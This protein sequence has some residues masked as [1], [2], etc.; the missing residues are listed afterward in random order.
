MS[1]KN[2]SEI[3]SRR[4]LAQAAALGG[5]GPSVG[6]AAMAAPATGGQTANSASTMFDVRQFGAKGDGKSD[7]TKAIQAA[8]DAGRTAAPSSCLQA[9][10]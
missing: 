4:H 9:C 3:Y 7:D 1:V 10:T 8:I 6:L 5:L 2:S